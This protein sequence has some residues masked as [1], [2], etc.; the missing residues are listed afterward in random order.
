[1]RRVLMALAILL[2]IAVAV[3]VLGPRPDTDGTITFDPSSLPADL[4]EY[5]AAS[6]ARV[7]AITPGAEKEIV[8]AGLGDE[9]RTQTAIVYV[10][11]F[12]ATKH[13]IRPVPDMVARVLG[14]NLFYTRLVGHGSDGEA[15]AD[16]RMNDWVQDFAEAI[17]IGERLGEKVIVIATSTGAT[18][19][20]WALEKPELMKNVAGVVF[21]SPNFA[22]HSASIGLL[23]MPWAETLLPLA[24]GQ[25]RQWEP[26][27]EEHGKW[28]THSYPSRAV[29]AMGALLKKAGQVRYEDV[30]APAL[31]FYSPDDQVIVPQAV[32]DVAGR[33]GGP[34]EIVAVE[35]ADDPSSHV[36]TGDILSPSTTDRVA[37]D[38]AR[39]IRS[40]IGE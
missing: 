8:W 12:S 39:W 15:L 16:A 20:A 27:N 38:I 24:M 29:F 2:I 25:T 33:W 26:H 35:D 32:R 17:A 13:E 37:G 4:D 5:L 19:T 22:V 36:I 3:F 23:N 30:G 7:E 10:H 14:A 40:V 1:M 21:V 18:L 6:E 11:G 9:T 31:F 34:I 28:T